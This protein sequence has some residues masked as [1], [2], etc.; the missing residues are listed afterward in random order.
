MMNTDVDVA[1]IGAGFAGLCAAIRLQERRLS[2]VIFERASEIGGTWRDNVYPGCAC[3]VPSHL[4]SLSFAPNPNWSRM[5]STQPEILAYLKNVVAQHSL[6]PTIR[7][8]TEIV[9][10]EF[11]ETTGY[12]TLTDR[13]GQATT[14]RVVIGA[15]GPLN[16]PVIPK[17]NGLET[18]AGRAFH[19][20]NWD[21]T[22]DLT[23]KRVAVIGTGA[24]AIQIVPQIAPKVRQLTIF[25]R[26]APYVTP[27]LDRAVSAVEQRI[28][29][30][31]PIAQRAYRAF[32]YWGNELRGLSFLGNKPIRT[33]ATA[34]ARKHLEAAISDPELRRKAMPDYQ[35]GC[36]RVLV[37]DDYY[38]A[39]TRPNVELVTD[40][41][42][43]IKPDAIVTQDGTLRPVDAIVFSTGFMAS[44]IICDLNIIGRNGRKLFDEWLTTGP[45][46][47][48]GITASGFPNLLFLVGPNTGLG[49]NSIVHMIESQVNYVLEYLTLL[50]KAGLGAFLDVKPEAQETYNA[51]IQQKLQGTV[52]ASGCQSWYLD[53]RGKNTTLWPALTVTYR[54]ATRRINPADYNILHTKQP[55]VAAVS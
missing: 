4:Y 5:Y 15:T 51:G 14:A 48:Y 28:F 1:I 38:P 21:H 35:I 20:A 11:S 42:A 36:K 22:Y 24:S 34:V 3:D 43:E 29:R 25:Q 23:D 6:K 50:G 32:I 46:A 2:L 39:L 54:K 19:S 13:A 55:S 18:F 16:R 44:E 9:R 37:S 8:N 47:H 40:R 17:L 52:W 41:I 45:E 10:T 26:T 33:I 53:S 27:R 49:H 30:R 12:W 7:Y 31:M